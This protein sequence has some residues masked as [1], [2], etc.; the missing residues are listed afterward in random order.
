MM[1]VGTSSMLQM[2]RVLL[3]TKEIPEWRAG[4]CRATALN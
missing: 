3:L 4:L 1:F 2:E